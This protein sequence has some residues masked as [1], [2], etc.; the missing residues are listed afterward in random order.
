MT[1][2]RQ[3]S[4]SFPWVCLNFGRWRSFIIF[5][6]E[7]WYLLPRDFRWLQFDDSIISLSLDTICSIFYDRE[8][9]LHVDFRFLIDY[10]FSFYFLLFFEAAVL[11]QALSTNLLPLSP[12]EWRSPSASAE[13]GRS[14]LLL[15][16]F[17]KKLDDLRVLDYYTHRH[18]EFRWL[19]FRYNFY[20]FTGD[21][22]W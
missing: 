22:R 18:F 9:Y 17:I 4:L 3:L 12:L 16:I 11:T 1:V 10:Y 15:Q 21:I 13:P 5:D 19:P 20:Y 14:R 6:I 2:R 7:Y 8:I